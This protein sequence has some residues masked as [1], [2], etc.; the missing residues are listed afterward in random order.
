MVSHCR[1]Y[2][3]A[4]EGSYL[5]GFMSSSSGDFTLLARRKFSEIAVV[6]SL[7]AITRLASVALKIYSKAYIL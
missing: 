3:G 1:L 2:K 4:A 5:V 7:P 6:V